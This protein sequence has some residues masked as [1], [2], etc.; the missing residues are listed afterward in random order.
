MLKTYLYIPDQ[1][2]KQIKQSARAQKKSKAEVMRTALKEGLN[3]LEKQKTGGAE[4]LLKLAEIAK[5]HKVKGPKDLSK[6]HD[7]Y[8]WGGVKKL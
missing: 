6:N 7:Y 2:E 5:K 1:L 8:L 4:I 3:V